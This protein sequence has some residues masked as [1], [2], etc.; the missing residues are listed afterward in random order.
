MAID[1]T[2]PRLKLIV[3]IG[4]IAVVTL[5]ALDFVLKSYLG[6]MNDEAVRSK[7]AP[8][9]ELDNH[10]KAEAA[11]LSNANVERAMADLARGRAASITPQPSDDL[12]S[13]T[14]WTK[15]PKPA[16]TPEQPIAPAPQD[17][18][19]AAGDAGATGDAG[20]APAAAGDAGAA[21]APAPGGAHGGHG[22][23][24]HEGHAPPPPPVPGAPHPH[25]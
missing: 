11:A 6:M 2:P 9:T 25:H 3:T 1:N 19:A 7:L 13:M 21:P 22:H 8:T 10:K 24:G 4:F 15:M 18:A 16:P 5:V 20:A 23:G 12:G 14:G 17:P